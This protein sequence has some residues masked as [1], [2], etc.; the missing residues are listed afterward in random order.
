MS[1]DGKAYLEKEHI[2]DHLGKIIDRVIAEKPKDAYSLVEVISR[3]VK[4]STGVDAPTGTPVEQLT[5]PEEAAGYFKRMRHLDAV[6]RDE[7]GDVIPVCLVPNFIAEAEMLSWAGVGF[8]DVE[9]YKIMCSMRNL[10]AKESEAGLTKLRF[11][12]KVLGTDADYYVAEAHRGEGE[13]PEGKEDMEVPGTPGV[14]QHAY[15][16]TNDLS[17][18]WRKLPDVMP[19]EIISARTIRHLLTGH[20]DEKVITHPFFNGTE[21]MLLRAQI[22]RIT[23]DTALCIKGFLKRDEEGEEDAPPEEDPEFKAPPASELLRMESWTHMAHHILKN[24]RTRYQDLPEDI[25]EEEQARIQAQRDADKPPDVIRDLTGD[26]LRWTMQQ[27]GDPT[28]YGSP[29]RST[30]VTCIRSLTW[31]GAVTVTRGGSFIN[32]YVGYGLPEPEREFFPPEPPDVQE[33][34]DDAGEQ[35]QPPGTEEV[36]DPSAEAEAE[37]EEA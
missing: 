20:P 11:W 12:G 2:T 24:G 34:P 23:S 21:A 32:F 17:E 7:N 28:S 30:V 22:A 10:A 27:V 4:A 18:N 8:G 3:L 13:V 14:N 16:V 6:P 33:E 15:Y 5:A 36:E 31:P 1:D 19:S 37:A 26:E 25:E 35:L 29:P 9:S